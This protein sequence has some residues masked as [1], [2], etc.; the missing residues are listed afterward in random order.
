MSTLTDPHPP[1]TDLDRS[2]EHRPVAEPGTGTTAAEP[3]RPFGAHLRMAWW[4]PPIIL[5]TTLVVMFVGSIVLSTIALFAEA[6]ISGRALDSLEMTPLM[7]LAANLALI[8]MAPVAVLL[9][10]VLSGTPVR[11]LLSASG[12]LRV[13]RMLAW[14]G[15]FA[16]LVL[17]GIGAT[18]LIHPDAAGFSAP[19]SITATTVALVAIAVLTTPLQAAAE[20]L[21]FRGAIMPAIGSWFRSPRVALAAGLVGSSLV[22][23]LVHLSVD[24]WLLSYYTVFGVCMALMT[25]LSRGLEAPIAFHATNNV[26]LMVIGAL[27]S[28]GGGIVIDRSVGMGGPFMLVFIAVDAVAVMLVWLHARRARRAEVAA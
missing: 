25:I 20:E 28:G 27:F 26:V 6:A 7:I 2:S 11:R 8:L 10:A 22:F 13:R 4:K 17:V 5:V 19:L 12:G 21:A 15:A 23:G 24:P 16:V 14:C 3:A 1:I 18:A 9:T